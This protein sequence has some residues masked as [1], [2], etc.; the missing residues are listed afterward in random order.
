GAVPEATLFSGSS[1]ARVTESYLEPRP[2]CTLLSFDGDRSHLAT[3]D[4]CILE[5]E[6]SG[7]R[8]LCFKRSLHQH[9]CSLT[10]FCF[11]R[12]NAVRGNDNF[13]IA[14]VSIVSAKEHTN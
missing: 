3:I 7:K 4:F 12:G 13:K 11:F 9:Q 2:I 5:F 14:H 6:V 8:N 10:R 1:S